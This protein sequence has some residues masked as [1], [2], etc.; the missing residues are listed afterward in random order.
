MSDDEGTQPEYV[1]KADLE[2]MISRIIQANPVRDEEDDEEEPSSGPD[3]VKTLREVEEWSKK[4]VEDAVNTLK[5]EMKATP[6][7]KPTP[8]VEEDEKPKEPEGEQAPVTP[9]KKKW[10]ERFW[11]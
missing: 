7:P 2:E 1:T 5:K 11:G 9:G 8:K 3:M 6:K 4:L 10:G